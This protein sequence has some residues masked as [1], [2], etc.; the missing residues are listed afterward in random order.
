MDIT[1]CANNEKC[2]LKE[3]CLRAIPNCNNVLQSRALFYKEN[4]EC[5]F[6]ADMTKPD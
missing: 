5:R 4:E 3:Y 6:F 2:E 1:L